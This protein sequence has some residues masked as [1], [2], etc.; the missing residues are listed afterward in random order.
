MQ[1]YTYLIE[2]KNGLKYMGVRSCKCKPEEDTSYVGSS[3]HTPNSSEILFKNIL[4]TYS[5]RAEAI[6][7]EIAF[8]AEHGVATNSEYYNKSNQTNTG[9]DTLGVTF[10]HTTEHRI[11]I[12]QSLTGRKRSPEECLAISKGKTGKLGAKHSNE[13]KRKIGKA[14]AGKRVSQESIDKMVTTRIANDSFVQSVNTKAKISKTLLE[15]PPNTTN[16]VLTRDGIVSTYDSIKNCA[17]QSG[18]RYNSLRGRLQRIPGK[19]VNGWS[20]EYV[21]K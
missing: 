6:E 18:I 16:V 13:T 11:K 14:H 19:C 4:N 9:F 8:H 21:I 15:N 3:K 2:Y 17:R 5:S 10:E 7:A 12:K 1:H 20:I